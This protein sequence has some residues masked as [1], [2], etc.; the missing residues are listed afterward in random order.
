MKILFI[1]LTVYQPV[2]IHVTTRFTHVTHSKY[3]W[4]LWLRWFNVTVRATMFLEVCDS[5][6]DVFVKCVVSEISGQVHH[7][8]FN[9]LFTSCQACLRVEGRFKHLFWHTI[10][11]M[12]G[13]VRQVRLPCIFEPFSIELPVC[14]EERILKKYNFRNTLSTLRNNVVI[15]NVLLTVHHSKSVQ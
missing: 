6:S 9:K 2:K 3:N 11:P 15:V 4:T 7:T 14:L 8:V 5:C 1:Q 12:W 13:N 10:R